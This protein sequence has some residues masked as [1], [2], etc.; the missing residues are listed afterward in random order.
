MKKQNVRVIEVLGN[1]L[2]ENGALPEQ[3]KERIVVAVGQIREGWR[4]VIVLSGGQT[5]KEYLSEAE[6]ALPYLYECLEEYCLAGAAQVLLEDKSRTTPENIV[7]LQTTLTAK[8]IVPDELVVIGRESQIP[9]TVVMVGE[10]WTLGTPIKIFIAS[11]DPSSLCMRWI[12]GVL[13]TALSYL[14]PYGNS[15]VYRVL[16][17]MT[18]NS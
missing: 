9:K 16:K 12:D 2:E 18:R 3:F 11:N 13:F 15:W 14:D 6:M 5:R 7:F 8:G 10:V 17:K 1:R 4:N